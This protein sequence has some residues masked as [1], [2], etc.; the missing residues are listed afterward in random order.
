MPQQRKGVLLRWGAVPFSVEI[1][2]FE[3][4]VPL[5]RGREA[6][7]FAAQNHR[8][9]PVAVKVFPTPNADSVQ[10]GED[11]TVLQ[12]LADHPEIVPILDH[13]VTD[14]GR[15]YV[16]MPLLA[17][18]VHQVAAGEGPLDWKIVAQLIWSVSKAVQYGHDRGISHCAVRPENMLL[19]EQGHALVSDFGM[20][21][22]GV[23]G[24]EAFTEFSAPERRAGAPPSRQSDVYSLAASFLAL[25]TGSP[26]AVP[27]DRGLAADRM[28]AVGVP[29]PVAEVVAGGLAASADDR[30][31]TAAEFA[32]ELRAQ[33]QQ[34]IDTSEPAVLPLPPT[35]AT[36]GVDRQSQMAA[37]EAAENNGQS[38]PRRRWT[39]IALLLSLVGLAYVG[40]RL[41]PPETE[42]AEAPVVTLT[43]ATPVPT[44]TPIPD[45]QLS[46]DLARLGTLAGLTTSGA[47]A[48]GCTAPVGME[49]PT[50][51]S[52]LPGEVQAIADGRVV[53]LG[54]QETVEPPLTNAAPWTWSRGLSLGRFVVVDHGRTDAA[55]SAISVYWD[56]DAI[57]EAMHIGALVSGGQP[58]GAIDA[59]DSGKASLGWELWRD[60]QL[61]GQD[62]PEEAP[63]AVAAIFHA[64]LL[65][66]D[67]LVPA[68]SCTFPADDPLS[69][70]NSPRAYRSGVHQGIDFGCG[71]SDQDA[72]AAAD[73]RVV[74][75]MDVYD[76]PTP[77]DRNAILASAAAAGDTPLWILTSLYGKFVA[78]EH[79]QYAAE[80]GPVY[81]IYAHLDSVDGGISLGEQ[82]SAGTR[83]GEVG[84][85]G[86]SLAASGTVGESPEVI[87]LHWE[88]VVGEHYL[89]EQLSS[90][91]TGEIYRQLLCDGTFAVGCDR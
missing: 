52:C 57:D 24:T 36:D 69:L 33:A 66:A 6:T 59:D 85:S 14:D 4:L 29:A 49:N 11:I 75:V 58:V 62:P 40:W 21:N 88:L 78:I 28:H 74:M 5:G 31:A 65:S 3:S 10:F 67:M 26:P 81:T 71:T 15:A 22:L 39:A 87:H 35:Q 51:W 25:V 41:L 53:L 34:W 83:V 70:P 89:A 19:D 61:P 37:P 84:A 43:P 20:A 32:A 76:E 82:V 44:A 79:P 50:Y 90:A 38:R 18:S 77:Q 8:N 46:E 27:Q 12:E 72:V 47:P 23:S 54:S 7:V 63:D 2:G 68:P 17:G 60:D 16:V 86:T 30:P 56:L 55:R 73:G 1:E 45:Q 13:G 48:P 91:A 9:E 80:L 42:V 64:G